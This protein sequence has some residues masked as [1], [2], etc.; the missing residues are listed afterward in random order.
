[1]KLLITVESGHRE[2][3]TL[4]LDLNIGANLAAHKLGYILET[5][6]VSFHLESETFFDNV[7]LILEN[8]HYDFIFLD[9]SL[10]GLFNY[11]LKPKRMNNGSKEQLFKNYFGIASLAIIL[12]NS[13]EKRLLEVPPIEV[14]AKKL[15]AE[16]AEKMINFIA[17]QPDHTLLDSFGAT[18][19]GANSAQGGSEPSKLL[20][21]LLDDIRILEELTPYIANKPLS[22]LSS[23]LTL[24]NGQN[25]EAIHE[26]GIAWLFDN[27]SVLEE[28]DSLEESHL[29]IDNSYF[30]A[31]E[32]QTSELKE[33][34]DIYENRVIHT[35]IKSLLSFTHELSDGLERYTHRP[36]NNHDGYVSFFT[37]MNELVSKSS[38]KNFEII[39][40]CR[41]RLLKLQSIYTRYVPVSGLLH[42]MPRISEKVK[43]NRHYILLYRMMI[44]WYQNNEINWE[45][46][47]FLLAITAIHKLFELYNLIRIKDWFIK[48]SQQEISKF[49]DSSWKGKINGSNIE[50]L[51]EPV[52]W[53]EGHSKS[54][55]IVNS[56]HRT[57]ESS[58]KD[59][60]KLPR[61]FNNYSNRS[62]DFVISKTTEDDKKS[63]I[64]LDAKYTTPKLAYSRYLPECTMKYVHGITSNEH[65]SITT[66][67]II[68][69]PD[70]HNL[71]RDF[72]VSEYGV[73]SDRPHI[74]I[75]GA[76]AISFSDSESGLDKILDALIKI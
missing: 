35:Y 4:D 38:K 19:L 45:S 18:R 30:A 62:P 37:A 11:Y 72:H 56:E 36:R 22:S 28:T 65:G 16:Q 43:A 27:L 24:K 52:Y 31:T 9:K 63:L 29:S 73:F 23:H 67:M 50:L 2:G 58:L 64:I 54:K 32:I 68:L 40:Q 59:A 33:N 74:P 71:F 26:E 76:Q 41:L 49:R 10:D 66:S 51:Y 17:S 53:M 70:T 21:Q 5:E 15:S 42:E 3:Y 1:M 75:L 7:E 47:K 55:N 14:L 25:V 12:S 61:G 8:I 44:G 20:E 69:H 39:E 57:A 60:K 13:E 48:N 6:A 46:K 34:T